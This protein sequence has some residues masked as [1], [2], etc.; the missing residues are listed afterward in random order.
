MTR[1]AM[2]L[3]AFLAAG[4]PICAQQA[5]KVPNPDKPHKALAEPI[6]AWDVHGHAE[7]IP[8][9]TARVIVTNSVRQF[10]PPNCVVVAKRGK[11]YDYVAASNS[12]FM[13]F[14]KHLTEQDLQEFTAS[15]GMV[16]FLPKKFANKDVQS[17]LNVCLQRGSE[18]R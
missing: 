1:L 8:N 5:W 16:Q 6:P 3:V 11:R 18:T 15:G 17:A 12:A 4:G 7:E 13:Q 10:S 14:K 2:A 9:L